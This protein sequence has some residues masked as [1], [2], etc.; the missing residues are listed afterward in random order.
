MNYTVV[1]RI[2]QKTP[3]ARPRYAGARARAY[4]AQGMRSRLLGFPPLGVFAACSNHDK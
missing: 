3:E 1:K 2:L 4:I